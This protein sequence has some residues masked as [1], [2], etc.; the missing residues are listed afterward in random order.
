MAKTENLLIQFR[1]FNK[2][3]LKAL[4]AENIYDI[5]FVKSRLKNKPEQIMSKSTEAK[6]VDI[7]VNEFILDSDIKDLYKVAGKVR[8]EILKSA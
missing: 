8:K 6:A 1:A 3:H 5:I 4:L 7:A 2:K